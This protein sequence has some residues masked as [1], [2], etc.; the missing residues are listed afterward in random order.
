MKSILA[1][2]L[3]RFGDLIL[4]TAALG[5]LR[6]TYPN[7]RIS[8]V[9]DQYCRGIAVALSMVDQVIVFDRKR[10]FG[11]WFRL[12]RE[13]YDV[14]L[15]FSGNDRAALVTFLAKAKRR[16]GFRF[17]ERRRIRTLAY[18]DL[19]DSNV[20]DR[21]TV[22]H[23]LDLVAAVGA[24]TEGA[25]LRLDIPGSVDASASEIL[26]RLNIRGD[27]IVVHPGAARP[28]KLWV[29]ERWAEVIRHLL[30]RI[31]GKVLITGGTDPIELRHVDQ[32]QRSLDRPDDVFS[33]LG[34]IDFMLSAALIKRC[35][36]F[37]SV[38]SAP[39]HVA[40]AFRRPELV[41]FGPTNPYHWRPRHETGR[42]LRAGYDAPYLSFGPR[43]RGAPMGELSTASVIRAID[44]LLG[45]NDRQGS[46][47][48]GNDRQK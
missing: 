3:K 18:T 22:D 9:I 14:S 7:A 21:H 33:L 47:T 26:A 38:D 5:A 46:P 48:I 35:R 28:E 32:I 20:R 11:F 31:T 30:Q 44:D 2:Q 29:P 40:A 36:L 17:L 34:K 42:V 1:I 19:I 13:S 6:T 24:Q 37:V 41:L 12:M 25:T 8:L 10:N 23:Y 43:Q 27:Y 39:A 4:T 15:D 45:E 16:C